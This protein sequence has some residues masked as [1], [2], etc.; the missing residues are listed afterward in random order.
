MSPSSSCS[1][2]AWPSSEG[3]RDGG[4]V[5]VCDRGSGGLRR[6]I[7]CGHNRQ[8]RIMCVIGMCP[9]NGVLAALTVGIRH[10]TANPVAS[11]RPPEPVRQHP[12]RAALPPASPTSSSPSCAKRIGLGPV[13]VA[14]VGDG[15]VDA[16]G[17]ASHQHL[18]RHVRQR[19]N[20][21]HMRHHR[22]CIVLPRQPEITDLG[23]AA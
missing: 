19:A 18:G 9:H 22:G 14:A 11:P 12:A 17:L 13:D 5:L 21:C 2:R 16:V 3:R 6:P 1:G 4:S 15:L 20:A 8:I 10:Q 23:L 7:T